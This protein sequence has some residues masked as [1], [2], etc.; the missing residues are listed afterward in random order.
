[1]QP[2]VILGLT[3]LEIRATQFVMDERRRRRRRTQL[4]TE[5]LNIKYICKVLTATNAP[6]TP[7][8]LGT[9][10]HFGSWAAP[11]QGPD[12]KLWIPCTRIG[13]GHYRCRQRSQSHSMDHKRPRR[14]NLLPDIDIIF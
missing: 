1:M 14:D 9:P 5:G 12:P 10:S 11:A 4:I 2:L 8:D 7:I 3:L 6:G 13:E